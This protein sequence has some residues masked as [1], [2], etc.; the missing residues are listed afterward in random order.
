M[1]DKNDLPLVSIITPSFNQ[2]EYIEE[3]I[4]SVLD[5]DYPNIEYIIIDGAST[6]GSKEIIEKYK[7][8][9]NFWVSEPDE[10]QTD[11]INKGFSQANGDIF[12]WLNSDDT[13][14]PQAVTEAVAYLQSHPEVGLL[15]LSNLR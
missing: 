10:G 1:N 15:R 7:D 2:A 3:T 13:Y 4:N 9:I 5:Q 8:R 12:A 14:E 6:D 11:A